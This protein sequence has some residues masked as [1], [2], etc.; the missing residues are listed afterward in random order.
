[1]SFDFGSFSSSFSVDSVKSS[2]LSGLGNL[3]SNSSTTQ[4]TS[5]SYS[6]C[7]AFRQSV[8]SSNNFDVNTS[9]MFNAWGKNLNDLLANQFT[10]DENSYS[11][12][13]QQMTDLQARA[14]LFRE[15]AGLY[16]GILK[17]LKA[18]LL[19]PSKAIPSAQVMAMASTGLSKCGGS[20]DMSYDVSNFE[21]VDHARQFSVI[22]DTA[23]DMVN[24]LIPSFTIELCYAKLTEY[25]T[26]LLTKNSIILSALGVIADVLGSIL[27]FITPLVSKVVSAIMSPLKNLLNMPLSILGN[28]GDR[29]GLGA[30]DDL[31]NDTMDEV[32]GLINK[33]RGYLGTGSNCN[34]LI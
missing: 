3:L 9:S 2:A 27:G 25:V 14:Q 6:L 17:V 23:G 21:I 29:L 15:L 11:G 19:S 30:F 10:L 8:Y 22:R 7:C 20:A 18:G 5:R 12:W 1:M 32:Y 13:L 34:S 28:L 31:I 33:V 16:V 24:S 26:S 4:N